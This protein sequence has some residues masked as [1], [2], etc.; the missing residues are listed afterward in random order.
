MET[1][2]RIWCGSS[3]AST[4][5]LQPRGVF[6]VEIVDERPGLITFRAT[7]K[8]VESTFGD[9]GGGHRWQ[10]IPP[11]EKRGRVHTSTVTVAVLP[12]P[13]AEE[14]TL[15]MADIEW[16]ACRGSGP[17]GQNRNKVNSAVQLWHKPSGYTIRCESERSQLQNKNTAIAMMRA[18][19]W[20]VK[21][22]AGTAETANSR[23]AQV[24][25]GM[26]GDKR[27]TIRAQDGQVVDH[28]TGKRWRF[29]DYVRGEW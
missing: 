2:R 23:R 19:L 15:N 10:R 12:E 3:L 21:I 27:R 18:K 8:E 20:E 16:T 14:F 25:S 5:A 1:T 13:S 17:G 26:R 28:V 22:L 24:G 6:D 7:G 11:N 29:K 9:E 4:C